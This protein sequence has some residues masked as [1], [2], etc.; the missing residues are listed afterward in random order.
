M[1]VSND[2]KNW[3]TSNRFDESFIEQIQKDA[4][5]AIQPIEKDKENDRHVNLIEL[6]RYAFF[7]EQSHGRVYDGMIL[8]LNEQEQYVYN[9]K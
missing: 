9:F 3:I 6:A 7:Y 2:P 8:V 4:L 5:T 1:D